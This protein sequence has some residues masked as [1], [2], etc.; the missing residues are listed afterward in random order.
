MSTAGGIPVLVVDDEQSLRRA[1]RRQLERRGHTVLEAAS[2]A[3]ARMQL[4][5]LDGALVLCDINMPGE[6]GLV[7]VQALR[8]R[9]PEVAV[10]MVTA[11][12]EPEVAAAAADFGAYGYVVKPFEANELTISVQNALRRRELEIAHRRTEADL[13][14]TIDLR[15]IELR[16]T[17]EQVRGAYEDT[18]RRLAWAAEYRD[19]E[20]GN[21]LERMS[22]Y[23]AVLAKAIGLPEDRVELLRMAAP[24]HDIGKVGIPDA[25]LCKPG[26][27]DDA[28]RAAMAAH[29]EI[30]HRILG[31]SDSELLQIAAVVALAHHE[32]WDGSGYP[33]GLVGD[34]IPLEGRIV[35][36][37]DVF[38]ALSSRRRYKEAFALDEAFGMLVDGAGSHFDPDLVAA[39]VSVRDEVEAIREAWS[40]HAEPANAS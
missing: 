29:P 7:L 3:E 21:H 28:D 26:K 39:F 35:A 34:A 23:T 24:M 31:G 17:L 1:V 18:V 15:T 5:E 4:A 8:R 20:T 6:S 12:D 11:V 9:Q 22:R 36:I 27:Y 40:D 2:V 14:A 33:S 25:I 16:E 30:G 37:A 10:L 19:P 32:K 38:D 13:A